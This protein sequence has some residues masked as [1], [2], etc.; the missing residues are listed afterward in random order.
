MT[1]QV[2]LNRIVASLE[3]RHLDIQF[4]RD[5]CE[6]IEIGELKN[7]N[8]VLNVNSRDELSLV[9]TIAHLFGHFCQFKNYDKYKHLVETVE[10]PAPLELS[11]GFKA[12]FW[13][14]EK[15][16]FGI[17]KTLM[18]ESFPVSDELDNLYQIFMITDF[19]HFWD[20]ITTGRNEGIKE[21]NKRLDNYYRENLKFEEKVRPVS[22]PE[23][24]AT[25][26]I[27]PKV[28]IY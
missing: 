26:I 4:V 16:A 1:S 18:M 27:E 12:E 21:F 10:K 7:N 3:S 20:Y 13:E 11:S 25:N 19:E 9:F 24:S 2:M 5:E 28:I 6:G 23:I 17:G 22:I 14:Y 8:I 15:E